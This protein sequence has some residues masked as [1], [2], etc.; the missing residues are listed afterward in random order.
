MTFI[1]FYVFVV[2]LTAELAVK[3]FRLTVQLVVVHNSKCKEC[4]SEFC[5]EKSN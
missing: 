3:F 2:N 5:F 4:E 1:C